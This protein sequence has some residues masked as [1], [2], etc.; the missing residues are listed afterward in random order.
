MRS[1]TFNGQASFMNSLANSQ[2]TMPA[3]TLT[4]NECLVP[5]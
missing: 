5:N 3:V 2:I 4:F 1:L